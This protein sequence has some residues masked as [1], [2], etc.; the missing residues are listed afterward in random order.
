[1]TRTQQYALRWITLA[2]LLV[3]GGCANLMD[4][5]EPKVELVGIEA[6]PSDGMEPRFQVS[7]RIVN[8]NSTAMTIDGVYYELSLRGKEFMNGATSESTSVPGY[9]EN[10]LSLQASIGLMKM[11]SLMGDFIRNPD[12][13]KLDYQF[14]AKIDVR[15]LLIPLH[16]TKEGDI[17]AELLQRR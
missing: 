16:I 1:M 3:L 6:L 15:E 11:L 8:P 10:T 5:E 9:G 17:S 2:C 13:P 12:N 7:L 14:K 4:F